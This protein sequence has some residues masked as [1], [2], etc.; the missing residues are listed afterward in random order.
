MTEP[1]NWRIK[2]TYAH[3]YFFGSNK[4]LAH[5]ARAAI[6]FLSF[7]SRVLKVS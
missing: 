5:Q 6:F 7:S 4:E 2:Q 1:G 3:S